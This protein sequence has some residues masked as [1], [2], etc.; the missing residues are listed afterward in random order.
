MDALILSAAIVLASVF[1]VATVLLLLKL[2]HKKQIGKAII[3]AHAEELDALRKAHAEALE[4]ARKV[5]AP[6]LECEQMLH[7]LTTRGQCVLH[8]NVVDPKNLFI[9]RST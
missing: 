2:H 7:D 1:A 6:T 5:P 4:A 3:R 9:R 8:I